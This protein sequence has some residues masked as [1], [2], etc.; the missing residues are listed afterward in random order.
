[1]PRWAQ[2]RQAVRLYVRD[3]PEVNALIDGE[4]SSDALIDLFLLLAVEDWNQ[5]PPLESR[6]LENHPAP[7]ILLLS[8]VLELLRSAGIGQARNHLVYNDGGLTV[9]TS[10]KTAMYQSWMQQIQSE[11]EEK[12]RKIKR[13]NNI[14]AC[15]DGI[16]SDYWSIAAWTQAGLTGSIANG[17]S[18]AL[19]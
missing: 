17:I 18:G 10:D 2:L 13:Y 1:M 19:V 4:E 11:V 12:K 7:R 16:Y 3:L 9:A 15:Y 6:T 5:T 14:N 8:A